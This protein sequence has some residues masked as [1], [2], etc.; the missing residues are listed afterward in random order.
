MREALPGERDVMNPSSYPFASS[1]CFRCAMSAW[2][3]SWPV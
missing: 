3:A 2:M 1:A